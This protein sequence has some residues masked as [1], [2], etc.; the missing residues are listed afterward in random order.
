MARDCADRRGDLRLSICAT[1]GGL[2]ACDNRI[3]RGGHDSGARVARAGGCAKFDRFFQR[4]TEDHVRG[5]ARSADRALPKSDASVCRRRSRGGSRRTA[6]GLKRRGEDRGARFGAFSNRRRSPDDRTDSLSA[7][8]R[9]PGRVRLPGLSRAR[10]HCGD[11]DGAG[12]FVRHGGVFDRRLSSAARRARDRES[13]GQDWRILRREPARS[14]AR[15]DARDRD[16]RSRRDQRGFAQ[17]FRAHRDGASAGDLGP[18]S[19]FRR[20]PRYSRSCGC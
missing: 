11:G 3:G 4:R 8:R 12:A 10:R 6:F 18:A 15:R 19:E 14:G 20:R 17:S 16:R 1:A 13:A 7:Q 9:Q 2:R 5:R